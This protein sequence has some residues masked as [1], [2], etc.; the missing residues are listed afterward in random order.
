MSRFK[1]IALLLASIGCVLVL[2]LL[3]ML[4]QKG[5]IFPIYD[6]SDMLITV[7]AYGLAVVFIF[8]SI[9]GILESD[10]SLI[11]R[12]L[13]ILLGG[14]VLLYTILFYSNS[15]SNEID[16]FDSRSVNFFIGYF[17]FSVFASF[18]SSSIFTKL[19]NESKTNSD[20]FAVTWKYYVQAI[21]SI[22]L[23]YFVFIKVVNPFFPNP[24]F[25]DHFMNY[26]LVGIITTIFL[27]IFYFVERRRNSFEKEII[28]QST[29]AETATAN[30]ET[31]KNQLD[32]HFLFNSLNVLTGLIEENPDKAIDFTTSLSKI[33]RYLL[34]QK[35]KEVVL[36]EEEIRFAKTYIN[37]LKLRFENSIHFHMNMI[38]FKE[39]EF[40][41]PLSLQILL[42]NTIKHNIVTESKPLKI[43]I[44]KENGYLIVENS[45][46]PKDS[47][48]DSTGVGLN[49]IKN[50]Y[51]LISNREVLIINE[52][53]LFKVELPI[54]T[55]KIIEMTNLNTP[56]EEVYN[57]ARI[58]AYK[59]KKFYRTLIN[60]VVA[61][62]V[63]FV[64]NIATFNGSWWCLWVL[65]GTG[66]HC[67]HKATKIYQFDD[68]W[69]KQKIQEILEKNKQSKKWK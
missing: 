58:K 66:L 13:A 27:V 60:S 11:G 5:F 23:L 17:L 26:V 21:I 56:D 18:I 68:D 67:I 29:K 57:Q 20:R 10:K 9:K 31:L 52:N 15:R 64:V 63:C 12:N 59:L 61:V 55:S 69:E 45:Y 24:I 25:Y 41:V 33:Y 54:L 47:I 51:Q 16:Y 37:L 44:Y 3:Q 48:K 28:Q 22:L 8:Q 42:E 49:N 14:N 35:D 32:P 40:I 43:R 38:D 50:R 34:E 4:K 46:Q 2:F 1:N 65:L 6:P 30:F 53:E 39:G 36:L 62:L 7:F 19:R